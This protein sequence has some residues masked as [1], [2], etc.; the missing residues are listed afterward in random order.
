M[1]VRDAVRRNGV[2]I[3]GDETVHRAA[4][5]MEEAGVGS[6]V[7]LDH[8][9]VVG[10]VTD[11]DLVRRVMAKSLAPD[12]RVDGVMSSPAVTVDADADLHDAYA[13]FRDHPVRRIVV[14]ASGNVVGVVTIDDLLVNL[15][16]QLGDLVRPVT[17]E[18][19]FG[20]RDPHV[21]A[22]TN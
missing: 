20:Q 16:A 4:V 11:R 9:T 6:L 13:V 18:A 14:T 12:A 22:T 7:V 19:I 5:I 17:V 1:R 21:P 3:E 8:G 15:S 10:V 2:T